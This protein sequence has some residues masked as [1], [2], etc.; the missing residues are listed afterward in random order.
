MVK[1]GGPGAVVK[2]YL[3]GKLGDRGF[4]PHSGLQVSKKQKRFFLYYRVMTQNCGLKPD[5][6]LF[7]CYGEKHNI[8]APL[9]FNDG[10]NIQIFAEL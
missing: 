6:F 1:G 2:S 5:S 10:P 4:E 7:L 9:R 8:S 3:L